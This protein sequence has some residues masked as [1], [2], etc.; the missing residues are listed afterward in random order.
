MVSVRA[1]SS[2]YLCLKGGSYTV[3]YTGLS[4][5]RQSATPSSVLCSCFPFKPI[6]P[7]DFRGCTPLSLLFVPWA[8]R[9]EWIL[10]CT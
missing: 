3:Y 10:L 7:P 9:K 1:D 6:L 5:R 8:Q 4:P 2:T